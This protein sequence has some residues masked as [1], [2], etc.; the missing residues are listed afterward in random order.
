MPKVRNKVQKKIHHKAKFLS[1]IRLKLIVSFVLPVILI[2]TLGMTAIVKST[3]TI[4]TNYKNSTSETM[5]AISDYLELGLEGVRSKAKQIMVEETINDYHSAK[6]KED[7][8]AESKITEEIQADYNNIVL[9]EP[10]TYAVYSMSDHGKLISSKGLEIKNSFTQMDELFNGTSGNSKWISNHP[11]MDEILNINQESYLLSYVTK[12]PHANGYLVFD[13]KAEYIKK[14]LEQ[15]NLGDGAVIACV[16]SDGKEVYGVTEETA[17]DELVKEQ[18]ISELDGINETLKANKE[19]GSEFVTIGE[20]EYLFLYHTVGDTGMR[21]CGFVPQNAIVGQA[22]DIQDTTFI[23]LAIGCIL[24]AITG[25]YV[26]HLINS[27]ISKIVA[28]LNQVGT[29][30][31]TVIF[32]SKHKDE[33][34]ELSNAINHM[35]SNMRSL[36]GEIQQSNGQVLNTAAD[37]SRVS[38]AFYTSTK[39]ISTALSEVEKDV[40]RQ[41]VDAE[42]CLSEMNRLSEQVKEVFESSERIEAISKETSDF[43]SSGLQVVEELSDKITDTTRMT[44]LVITDIEELKEQSDN[45]G[46]IIDVINQI[47]EETNLLSLNASIEAARAGDAGR[48]FAVVADQIRKLADESKDA[49][50][51]IAKIVQQ[52]QEQTAGTVEAAK[53]TEVTVLSQ[54]ESLQSTVEVFN[55]IKSRFD[56]LS[57]QLGNITDKVTEMEQ[58]KET[59]L[60]SIESISSYTQETS[61][62]TEEVSATAI[63]Q[64]DSVNN[65]REEAKLLEG[66]AIAL[67]TSMEKFKV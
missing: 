44:G 60:L 15:I 5:K 14:Y 11:F 34:M 31:L 2:I 49:V 62:V 57:E 3:R 8:V 36:I 10:M 40:V 41:A 51:E 54:E 24:L 7:L 46:K 64:I 22:K 65:L 27:T 59:T 17:F 23:I 25:V 6:Y 39:E 13:V 47:A 28:K 18:K 9:M 48:G 21:V 56:I 12:L 37:V 66:E 33:F 67:N 43:V 1:S 58:V 4:S 55:T 32:E 29:G 26:A 50:A 63:N 16:T 30:D 53:K 52:I 20:E 61:A 45:I 35:L 38:D 19:S 42:N